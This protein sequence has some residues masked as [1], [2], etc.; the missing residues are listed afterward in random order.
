MRLLKCQSTLG[1][2][3]ARRLVTDD[4]LYRSAA[5]FARKARVGDRWWPARS[6]DIVV[7]TF[8]ASSITSKPKVFR[9]QGKAEIHTPTMA[10]EADEADYHLDTGEIE[11]HGNV[12]V[13]PAAPLQ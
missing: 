5:E 13:T 8:A 11:A 1:P 4:P 6:N 12:R 2:D 10:L 3:S 9:L 7:V